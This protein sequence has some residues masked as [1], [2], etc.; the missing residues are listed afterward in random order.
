MKR[1]IVI[2]LVAVVAG[3]ALVAASHDATDEL[4]GLDKK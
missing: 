3:V 4:I 2:G 1:F